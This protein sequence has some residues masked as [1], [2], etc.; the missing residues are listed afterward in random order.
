MKEM[1]LPSGHSCLVD[2]E[3]YDYLLM[4][5]WRRCAAGY[6]VAN[7]SRHHLKMGA[8]KVI[9]MHRLLLNAPLDMVVDHIDGN[10]LNNQK[11]NIRLCSNAQN[12]YNSKGKPSS[13]TG[14]KGV[15]GSLH[16][17]GW[18]DVF[19][20]V[21]RKTYRCGTFLTIR[22]AAEAYNNAAIKHFGD[23]A[24]PNPRPL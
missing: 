1:K 21:N 9:R 6:V 11:S 2:D 5:A 18:Y 20:H 17:P 14:V 24:R 16:R 12:S 22:E 7:T 8:P 19:I 10:K 15:V 23:F 13:K 3:D 4:W